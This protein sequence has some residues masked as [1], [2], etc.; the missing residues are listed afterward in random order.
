MGCGAGRWGTLVPVLGPVRDEGPALSP[1]SSG[2]L[3][4]GSLGLA[5]DV[6]DISWRPLFSSWD[7]LNPAEVSFGPF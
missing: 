4:Q 1:P 6:V 7:Y 3:L 5:L 2:S